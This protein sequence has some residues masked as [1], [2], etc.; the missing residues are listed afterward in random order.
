MSENKPG[1]IS[2]FIGEL[3]LFLAQFLPLKTRTADVLLLDSGTILIEDR[4]APDLL[5]P[6]ALSVLED[7]LGVTPE[8]VP[9]KKSDYNPPEDVERAHGNVAKVAEAKYN[10][11]DLLDLD[12]SSGRELVGE[13]C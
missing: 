11:I 1:L 12:F 2:T 13:E 8:D 6:L 4:R 5:A 10:R 9:V 7:E 3:S